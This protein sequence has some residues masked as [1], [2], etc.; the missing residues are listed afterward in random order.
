M[1]IGVLGAVAAACLPLRA[2]ADSLSVVKGD[3]A[4]LSISAD[5]SAPNGALRATSQVLIQPH[6]A[7]AVDTRLTLSLGTGERADG[8]P[9]WAGVVPYAAFAWTHAGAA[10]QTDWTAPAGVK[11]H[12]EASDDLR[13]QTFLGPDTLDA[14]P[15]SLNDSRGARLSATLPAAAGFTFAMGAG[16]GEDDGAV[17]LVDDS[18]LLRRVALRSAH[19]DLSSQLDWKITPTLSLQLSDRLES[20]SLSWGGAGVPD[21]YVALQPKAMAVWKPMADAEWTLSFEHANSPLDPAKFAALAQTAESS[22]IPAATARLRPDETWRLRA[23]MSRKF[24]KTGAFSVAFTN[25]DLRSSTELVRLAPGVQA[26]GSV[27]GGQRQQWDVALNLPLDLVGLDALSLQSSG[28]WRRSLIPDP[29]TGV[30]R[31]PSGETPYEAKLGLVADL[32]DSDLRLGVQGQ[33]VGPQSVYS[34]SRVDAVSVSPSLGAFVEF[35]PADFALRLQ[36]DNL[37]GADRRYQST[38]YSGARDGGAPEEIDRRVIGGP[39][40]MLSFRR[41]L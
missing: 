19:S 9:V 21:G 23:A 5:A 10:L 24:R 15:M 18:A 3:G 1:R 7:P 17:D 28:L 36:L 22:S 37:T 39:G 11:L 12:L 33:A 27:T 13:T 16:A 2:H 38:Q 40:F 25:A 20:G 32:L 14:R 8:A 26:P 34:L 4:D 31:P 6:I 41:A 30:M 35:H 29:I